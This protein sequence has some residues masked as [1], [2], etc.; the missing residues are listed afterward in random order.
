MYKILDLRTGEFCCYWG[1]GSRI[2]RSYTSEQTAEVVLESIIRLNN[3]SGILDIKE[4]YEIIR[5]K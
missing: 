1:K 5:V 2:Q 3:N 4:F